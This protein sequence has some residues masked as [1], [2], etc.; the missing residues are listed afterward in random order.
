[1]LLLGCGRSGTSIFG[2]LFEA[3]PQYRYL[4]EPAC[5]ELTA[6][7]FSSPVAVKVPRSTARFPAGGGLSFPLDRLDDL[8][9]QPRAVFWIVRHPLDTICSLRV[10]ISRNWG[11]HPRPPDWQDWL[12]RPLLDRCAHHWNYIN[13]PGYAQ[14][15]NLAQLVYF[16]DMIADSAAFA[17]RICKTIGIDPIA[18][19]K[20]IN[21]W[22]RRVQDTDNA[23]FVPARTGREYATRDHRVRVGRWRENLPRDTAA[24]LWQK[25]QAQARPFGYTFP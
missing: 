22:A 7:D 10:G 20:A 5:D 12:D 1:L 16:E 8:L 17:E 23:D 6:L 18:V 15:R 24:D 4:S 19:A 11:H 9:P 21:T 3:L 2:E 13:G 14:V 25:V